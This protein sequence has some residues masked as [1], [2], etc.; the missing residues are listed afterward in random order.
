[1]Y[2]IAGLILAAGLASRMGQ[3]KQLLPFGEGTMLEMTTHT[4][5]EA[6]VREIYVVLGHEH[7]RIRAQYR[8]CD[9]VHLVHNP[10]YRQGMLTSVR[11]GVSAM[12]VDTQAFLMM[13]GDCPTAHPRTAQAIVRAYRRT[14][15]RIVR[16]VCNGR[17]GHPCLFDYG[18]SPEIVQGTLSEGMRTLMRLHAQE[19]YALPV[20]DEGI[21][22]DLDTPEQYREALKGQM[23]R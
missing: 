7:E 3:L 9:R 1:M 4:L 15:C 23:G 17:G 5:L 18:F 12:D 10:D 22:G 19:V 8:Y 2:G 16:P 20:S 6:G 13:P 14:G 21:W 11:V